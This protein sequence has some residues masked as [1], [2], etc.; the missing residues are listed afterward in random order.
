M[1]A[2]P[3]PIPLLEAP[4]SVIDWGR[5]KSNDASERKRLLSACEGQGFF[6][7]DLRSDDTFLRDW[8]AVLDFMAEY[9]HQDMSQKM[10][11][12]RKSDTH[13]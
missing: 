10:R 4:L 6:Y 1:G 2:Q 7:L 9:F 13:G 8:Q 5:L 12:D 11:D 3:E